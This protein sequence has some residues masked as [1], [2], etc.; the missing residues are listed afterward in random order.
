MKDYLVSVVIPCYNVEKY[1][2]RC[3][4]S[5]VNQTY[6]NLEII[7]VDD[8]S[9]DNTS[10]MCDKWAENDERIK[11][12]HKDNDGLANA[13]NS[14]IEIC[15]GEFTVFI[16]SDDFA[17]LDMVEF[18]LNLAVEYSADVSRCS[19]YT[20]NNG[21]DTK[22]L[23]DDTI[24]LKDRE[25]RFIDLIDGGH[26]SGVVWNKLY[27][28]ELVKEHLFDK[29]DGCSEDILFNYRL[30]KYVNKSVFCNVPKYH[31]CVN[32]NS[33]TNYAFDYGAFAIIRAR[34]IMMDEFKD[35]P[36]IYPYTVK[37]FV[38]SSFIVLSGCIK[39][40]NCLDRYNELRDEILKYKS[41]IIFGKGFSLNH[42]LR[43]IILGVSPKLYNFLIKH[44]G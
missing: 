4:E 20:Y 38:R 12:F 32:E 31:Y 7:L 5:I 17:D 43:T 28:T 37:W 39:S 26:L 3:L 6:R 41:V 19:F 9:V 36:A 24:V 14:G 33:I 8:G 42:K 34:R 13:R 10:A 22:D 15:S 11:V 16:D 44:K 18:L 35:N 2:D 29:Q 23:S 27:K 40:G 21:T 30:Y 25:E 1:L